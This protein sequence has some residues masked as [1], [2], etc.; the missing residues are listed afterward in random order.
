MNTGLFFVDSFG[1]TLIRT[2]TERK[3]SELDYSIRTVPVGA[4]Q[5][6]RLA[7][8][9]FEA[10]NIGD[11]VAQ[12]THP[13]LWVRELVAA[14]V[15]KPE[16]FAYVDSAGVPATREYLGTRNRGPEELRPEDILFY[17]GLGDAIGALHEVLHSGLRI[18]MPAPCYPSW[19]VLEKI[20]TG[21]APLFWHPEPN[22]G[23]Q[24]DFDD[25]RNILNLHEDIGAILLIQPS[26]PLGLTLNRESMRQM[27]SLA[28]ERQLLLIS[29]EIYRS[30]H[31]TG[32]ES[33]CLLE[34][35]SAGI[36]AI[37]F[38]GISK[39]IPWPGGRCGWMEFR[40]TRQF[41]DLGNLREV[42]LKRKMLEVGSTALPQ[43]V[44]P[45]LLSHPDYQEWIDGWN[46]RLGRL[47]GYAREVFQDLEGIEAVP[48]S[49]GFYLSMHLKGQ[50]LGAS[51]LPAG[52]A[53]EFLLQRQ[54]FQVPDASLCDQIVALSGICTVP[55]SGFGGGW[56]GFRMTLLAEEAVFLSRL[57]R[58]AQV[59]K[60]RVQASAGTSLA[61]P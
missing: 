20:R 24:P 29:D 34:E 12:G 28:R 6:A 21:K 3:A 43:R 27:A 48:S 38:K 44:L 56:Q 52:P 39:E 61:V 57:G 41:E 22:L 18:L 49:A 4:R 32:T 58:I 30:F 14:E 35:V 60:N 25:I 15:M 17:N 23:W 53:Q 31:D 50:V 40:G 10:E 36:R 2:L 9:E 16:S 37:S 13:P 46:F 42:L 55:L 5:I 54:R 19:A 45:Q 33:P 7:G 51:S 26:N 47:R 1:M 8:R 59:L 11:P